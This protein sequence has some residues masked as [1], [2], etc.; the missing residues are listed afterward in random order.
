M[1]GRLNQFLPQLKH[2]N[3]KLETNLEPAGG[4]ELVPVEDTGDGG[5]DGDEQDAAPHVEM[6]VS[7]NA[8][9]GMLVPT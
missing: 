8:R 3:E 4:P 5:S 7:C 1:L 9:C 2:A 6:V